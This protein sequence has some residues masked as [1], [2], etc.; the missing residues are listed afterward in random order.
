VSFCCAG[1]PGLTELITRKIGE[2]WLKDLAAL[3]SRYGGWVCRHRV[4]SRLQRA[5]LCAGFC[6][7]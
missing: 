4:R 3:D 1:Q 7:G 2:S 6:M 5:A